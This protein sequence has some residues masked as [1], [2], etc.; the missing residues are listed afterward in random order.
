MIRATLIAF[1]V[2]SLAPQARAQI[3]LG[4][5]VYSANPQFIET[6]DL[7]VAVEAIDDVTY[8]ILTTNKAKAETRQFLWDAGSPI[9]PD[10]LYLQR[11]HL[12][13]RGF[14]DLVLRIPPP[15]YGDIRS[16]SYERLVFSDDLSQLVTQMQDGSVAA[17][18]AVLPLQ[19]FTLNPETSG[20]DFPDTPVTC[21]NGIPK[22][23]DP[24]WQAE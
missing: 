17:A 23:P 10:R 1:A 2:L 24:V 3:A 15:R 7:R 14:V 13:G 8:L 20:F 5:E 4:Q 21:Q 9:Q 22:G 12:C 16:Y 11:S 19:V 18:N 6:K